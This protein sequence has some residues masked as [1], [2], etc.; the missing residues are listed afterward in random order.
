MNMPG[1][2]AESSLYKASG[3]YKLG[4]AWA[5]GTGEYP[6]IPQQA[7][8]PQRI[9]LATFVCD[10]PSESDVPATLS[11]GISLAACTCVRMVD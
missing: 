4:V 3:H 5:D 7:I 10:C 11:P 6:G 9:K 1:F 2:T 8:I